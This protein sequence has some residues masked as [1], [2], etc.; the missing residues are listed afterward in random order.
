MKEQINNIIKHA[1]ASAILI[2]LQ[3][4]A[5]QLILTIND[6]GKGFDQST[7]KKGLGIDNMINRT[8]IFNGKL[9]IKTEPGRGCSVT[10]TIPINKDVQQ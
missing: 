10:V 3:M 8:E 7:I 9:D 2:R 6:N 4:D 1:E 5:E